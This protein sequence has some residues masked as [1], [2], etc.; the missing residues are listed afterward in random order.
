MKVSWKSKRLLLLLLGGLFSGAVPL[1][2]AICKGH[3]R[4]RVCL[5]VSI[6]YSVM[7]L[8][9]AN[10]ASLCL[11]IWPHVAISCIGR[12]CQDYG[13]ADITNAQ[14]IYHRLGRQGVRPVT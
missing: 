5:G 2:V 11:S 1:P 3:K 12:P 14:T 13:F 10:S 6:D 4:G 7:E 9:L 8:L